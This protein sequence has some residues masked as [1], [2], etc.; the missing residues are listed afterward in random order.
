MKKFKV[1]SI[2]LFGTLVELRSIRYN[3]WQEFLKD[4]FTRELAD[5]YWDRASDMVF[6]YI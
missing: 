1:V 6:Q 3:V 2:D 5:R 4:K